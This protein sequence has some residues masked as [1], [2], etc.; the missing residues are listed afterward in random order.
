MLSVS[1][2]NLLVVPRDLHTGGSVDLG[3]GLELLLSCF[4]ASSRV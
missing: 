1:K 2:V 3:V 4:L